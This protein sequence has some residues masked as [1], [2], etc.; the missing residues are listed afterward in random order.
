[1]PK[2]CGPNRFHP[3]ILAIRPMDHSTTIS[4]TGILA[5]SGRLQ[6][7]LFSALVVYYW[8]MLLLQRQEAVIKRFSP[9]YFFLVIPILFFIVINI[10]YLVLSRFN[11]LSRML[12][13]YLGIV[14]AVSLFRLDYA[15][16]YNTAIFTLPIIIVINSGAV[17][18]PGFINR[19]FLL[20]ILGSI[21]TYYAG[22][23]VYGFLPGQASG[24][25]AQGLA[26]RVSLF[27]ALPESAFFCVLLFVLNLLYNRSRSR[28]AYCAA[29]LYFLLFSANRT[30]LISLLFIVSFLGV[31]RWIEFRPR[32]FYKVMIAAI[33]VSLLLLVNVNLIMEEVAISLQNPV[34]NNYVFRSES[35]ITGEDIGETAYRGWLWAQHYRIFLQHP[36]IGTGTFDFER[37]M[38]EAPPI[39]QVETTGSESF[40]TGLIARIGLLV[41]PLLVFFWRLCSQAMSMRNRYLYSICITLLVFSLA[42]GSFLVPYNCMFLIT[43]GTINLQPEPPY[44][45]PPAGEG[46]LVAV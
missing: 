44:A 34:L 16:I 31:T 21:V 9:F 26:Y 32:R 37:V 27:P 14:S 2:N 40:L 28:Y 38:D 6:L 13:L 3:D 5:P 35:G 8:F 39:L 30:A 45:H 23:N 46:R 7:Q 20:S 25:A 36:I 43:F 11:P 1:M 17:L 41:I 33:L 15:T 29:A 18:T 42:Y 22:N 12:L 10:P 24:S 19:L 4:E